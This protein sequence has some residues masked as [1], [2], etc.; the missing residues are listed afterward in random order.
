MPSHIPSVPEIGSTSAPLT[1]AAY[2]IGARCRP[3]NDDYMQ[4]KNEAGGKGEIDCLSEGRKVTRCAA[5]VLQDVTANCLDEF[6]AHWHC[7]ENYNH[8][9]WNCRRAERKLNKCVFDKLG[10]EKMIPGT[11]EGVVPVHLRKK[12]IYATL[13][14]DDPEERW[15][16]RLGKKDPAQ[17][18]EEGKVRAEAAAG[19]QEQKQTQ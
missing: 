9:L 2:F 13:P 4:C 15:Y 7:L 14:Q 5:S 17:I 6:R 16:R 12:Q 18:V 8:Q 11:P 19:L 3:F 10:L 1:S